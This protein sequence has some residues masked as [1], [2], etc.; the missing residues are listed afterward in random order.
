MTPPVGTLTPRRRA[1]W[2]VRG[3]VRALAGALGLA[4]AACVGVTSEPNSTGVELGKSTSPISSEVTA[5]GPL[6][7]TGLDG[8]V[9]VFWS[10]ALQDVGN[11]VMRKVSTDGGETFGPDELIYNVSLLGNVAA[12]ANQPRPIAAVVDEL[13]ETYMLLQVGDPD[14]GQRS[15]IYYLHR[16]EYAQPTDKAL[17]T[18]GRNQAGEGLDAVE[19]YDNRTR[20]WEPT[21]SAGLGSGVSCEAGV[22]T[23]ASPTRRWHHGSAAL[24][25]SM[26]VAGGEDL[27]GPLD[28]VQVYDRTLD[29]WFSYPP[30]PAPRAGAALV[31]AKGW[32]WVI[33]G[34][35][36]TG[37]LTS[38][39]R[40]D[41]SVQPS[42]TFDGNGAVT[43]CTSPAGTPW[44]GQ[45]PVLA[46]GRLDLEAVAVTRAS[47][48]VEVHVIGGETQAGNPQATV[49]S[50]R[51]A[52]NDTLSAIPRLP[53]LPAPR[54][55]HAAVAVGERIYVLGGTSNGSDVLDTVY[56]IDV[57]AGTPTWLAAPPM[58]RPRRGHRAV[59][60]EGR[61]YVL[62]GTDGL[63]P[64]P[65]V[66]VF[67]PAT[68]TWSTDR[69]S[70]LDTVPVD[71]AAAVFR[72]ASLPRNLSRQSANATQPALT[73]SPDINPDTGRRDLYAAW[74][75]EEEVTIGPF[76]TRITSD[77]YLTRS[78]DG[79]D[80]FLEEPVRLSGLGALSSRN[81]N[82]S[83][84]PRMAVDHDGRIHLA[85]IETGEPGDVG[86][87]GQ[88]LIYTNCVP[89][90]PPP[91]G[92]ANGIACGS[93]LLFFGSVGGSTPTDPPAGTMR[94][95]ALAVDDAGVVYLAWIDRD[96]TVPLATGS[97]NRTYALNVYFTR[98]RSTGTFVAPVPLG[99]PLSSRTEELFPAGTV[100]DPVA[101]IAKLAVKV[102]L[103]SIAAF[104][105]GDVTVLWTNDA[106]VRL[107]RSQDGGA[108]FL[109]ETGAAA[110]A[111]G[112]SRINPGLAYEPATGHM[113]AL[114]QTLTNAAT[115]SLVETRTVLPR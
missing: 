6:V 55:A 16:E 25:G 8:S 106:E 68:N 115:V 59:V 38:M 9:H 60:L 90:A 61:I 88:D 4:L 53:N 69:E 76:E 58:P 37:A 101:E 12:G 91:A 104:G 2:A 63:D 80:T 64:I 107:R 112:A 54:S 14:D 36:G 95:P 31:A 71:G 86:G 94:N 15:D 23:P 99:T 49:D 81:N 111:S 48:D 73:L 52:A 97:A 34:S 29:T 35:D 45:G 18:G 87:S 28:L 13:G 10:Q 108:S 114:W 72:E 79:G 70:A 1:P 66:D 78:A 105:N 82:F 65:V 102:D 84:S 3:A 33:G 27:D 46:V 50:F 32:L 21:L 26:F 85:W 83:G 41:P 19:V 92:A 24:N 113:V 62:G 67:D 103:P 44:T 89:E 98:R 43:G 51:V 110:L 96:G 11:V 30:L 57:A 93:T 77:V 42:F 40:F 74:R 100:T 22:V 75:N 5:N 109:L 47:G 39:L 17:V 7:V 56:T 20:Q